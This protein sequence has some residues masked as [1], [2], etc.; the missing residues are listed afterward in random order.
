MKIWDKVLHK[1]FWE[2]IIQDIYMSK[3]TVLFW[4]KIRAVPLSLLEVI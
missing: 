2:W 4:E 1:I 3:A